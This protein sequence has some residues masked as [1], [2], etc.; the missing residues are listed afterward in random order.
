MIG[1][2]FRQAAIWGGL[3]IVLYL[4]IGNRSL[5]MPAV[6]QQA[7]A[8]VAI[9]QHQPQ[10]NVAINTLVYHANTQGH[11]IIEAGVNGAPIRF[12]LDT[13]ATAVALSARDAAA[14][15][16]SRYQLDFSRRAETANG[17]VR[18]A[19]VNLREIRL[20]QLSVDDVQAVVIDNLEVSLLGQTFLK[21]L[22][23]YEMRDGV[24][25]ITW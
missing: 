11:V 22:Q 23:S 1:W 7:A 14:A 18:V 2:A 6:P 19:P 20:G 9:A 5:W 13:G 12:M 10:A 17:D 24:L 16:I 21:R 4:A 15:G 3:S 25:T 8:P